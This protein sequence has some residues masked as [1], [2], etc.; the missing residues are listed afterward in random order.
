MLVYPGSW[1]KKLWFIPFGI[2]TIH[3]INVLRIIGLALTVFY[4]P[5]PE[6]LDFNHTYTFTVLVY[7]YVFYLWF[8]WSK[9]GHSPTSLKSSVETS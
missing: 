6:L 3:L 8:L 5:D 4:F 1:K 2:I 9:I 7:G